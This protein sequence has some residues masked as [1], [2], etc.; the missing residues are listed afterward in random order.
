MA[1]SG[2]KVVVYCGNAL[3]G[4]YEVP[5]GEGTVWR[6]FTVQDNQLIPLNTMSYRSDPTTVGR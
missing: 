6:V 2:A 3:L 1:G 4:I 5:D